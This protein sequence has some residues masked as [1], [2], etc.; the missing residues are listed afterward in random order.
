VSFSRFFQEKMLDYEVSVCI[1]S[2][3][4]AGKREEVRDA[5]SSWF[6]NKCNFSK[7]HFEKWRKK[8]II[9]DEVSREKAGDILK[10]H[11]KWAK[12]CSIGGTPTLFM[13]EL[14]LPTE[15]Q[16]EDLKYFLMRHY[17]E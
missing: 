1:I 15:V 16:F 8:Y 6:S 2:M 10:L 11:R 9:C 3:A 14:R 17:K 5:L 7:G 12:N 13:N 4:E